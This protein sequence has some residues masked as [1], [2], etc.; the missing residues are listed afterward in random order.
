MSRRPGA[1]VVV[2]DLYENPSKKSPHEVR[3]KAHG[4]NFQKSFKLKVPADDFRSWLNHAIGAREKFSLEDGMPISWNTTDLTIAKFAKQ[5]FDQEKPTWQPRSR[6]SS[7]EALAICL[8]ALVKRSATPAPDTALKQIRTWLIS[9]KCQIPMWLA[10]NSLNISDCTFDV[11]EA[12]QRSIS[13]TVS[14]GKT[15]QRS[16]TTVRRYRIV[17]RAVFAEAVSK[18]LLP[19][20][21]WPSAPKGSTRTVARVEES[22]RIDLLPNPKQAREHIDMIVSH[23]PGSREHRVLAAMVYYAGMRPSEARACPISNLKFPVKG[24]KTGSIIVDVADKAAGKE[25]TNEAEELG[26]AKTKRREVLMCSPLVKILREHIGDR[27]E[28]LVCRTKSR[29]KQSGE[30]W[31]MIT[32]SNFSR[33]W[34]RARG[35]NRWRIYDL[36]HACATTWLSGGVPIGRVAKWLGHSPEV[37]LGVYAG[38]ME[39]D[40]ERSIAIIEDLYD[41]S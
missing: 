31:V 27:S 39:G 29:S 25:F 26:P 13:T 34:A 32:E 10:K 35:K 41:E 8:V 14:S 6:H 21:P 2:S 7:C 5:W 3:W 11:C 23:Q 16:A 28:G 18:D 9:D 40:D 15:R 37:L 1:P 20:Q 30:T 33:S 19:K 22:I 24:R 4:R 12:A 36:R 17:I 38:V